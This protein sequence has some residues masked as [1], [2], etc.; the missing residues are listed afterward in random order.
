M[1]KNYLK[2]AFR[3]LLKQKAYSAINIL[4]LSIGIA[5]CLLIV[6]FVTDEFSYD[7]FHAKADRIYVMDRGRAVESGT[8]AELL[9]KGGAYA[10]LYALQFAGDE[11]DAPR[12]AAAR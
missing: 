9:A 3:S 2:V 10:R 11:P 4:G 7:K 8:H 6:L 1:I 12:V 5:S